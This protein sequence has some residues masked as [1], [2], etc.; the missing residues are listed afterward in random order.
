M[1]TYDKIHDKKFRAKAYSDPES[2]AKDLGLDISNN[3][4]LVIKH[5]TK[6]IT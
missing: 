6:N 1:D 2:F 5:N 3:Q 4:D